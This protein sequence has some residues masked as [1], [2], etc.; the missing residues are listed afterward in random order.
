MQR[1]FPL[2][3]ALLNVSNMTQH[4]NMRKKNENGDLYWYQ[5]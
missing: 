1:A 5:M 4:M 2:K 3:K